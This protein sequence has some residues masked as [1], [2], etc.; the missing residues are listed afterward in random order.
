MVHLVNA[1]AVLARV[2]SSVGLPA[3][4]LGTPFG[5]SIALAD[6]NI[7]AVEGLEA[8]AIGVR[9]GRGP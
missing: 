1:A 8:R 3:P 9:I 2:V 7:L 5:H 4:A 6:K